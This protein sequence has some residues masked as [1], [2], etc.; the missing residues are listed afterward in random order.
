MRSH[1]AELD[2]VNNRRLNDGLVV[3]QMAR[4]IRITIRIVIT[5]TVTVLA[6]VLGT[7]PMST[8]ARIVAFSAG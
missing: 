6:L 8:A 7:V 2:G 4:L 5:I 1:A 3:G